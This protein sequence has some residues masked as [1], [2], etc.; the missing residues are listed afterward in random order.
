MYLVP[1]SDPLSAALHPPDIQFDMWHPL[2]SQCLFIAA[3]F[4][5]SAHYHMYLLKHQ[6]DLIYH[7]QP[8]ES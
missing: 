5:V 3:I 7:F 4:T 8:E 6:W 1:S 2:L